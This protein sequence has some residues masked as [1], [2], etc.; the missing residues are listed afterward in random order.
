MAAVRYNKGLTGIAS[1]S[2]SHAISDPES[3]ENEDNEVTLVKKHYLTNVTEPSTA[4]MNQDCP[5]NDNST[6]PLVLPEK[7]EVSKNT[8]AKDSSSDGL[9][10]SIEARLHNIESKFADSIDT[11]REAQ[12]SFLRQ[13]M[14][15]IHE[16]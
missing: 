8:H 16:Y 9:S 5:I 15:T 7:P 6:D 4:A 14:N 10:L 12:N 13:Q 1:L 2:D 3:D 11:L